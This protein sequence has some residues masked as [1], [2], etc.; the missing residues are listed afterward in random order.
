MKRNSYICILLAGALWGITG[1][2]FR[3]LTA[4]GFDS[5]EAVLMRIGFAAVLLFLF[6]LIRE[7][8]AFRVRL[9]DL[10]CMVGAG[11]ACLMMFICY[12]KA[13]E[14]A[15]LA[16]AVVL[17]YTAPGFVV[18][19][20]A[21]FFKE[22]ITWQ[23][24]LALFALFGGCVCS[25]GLLTGSQTMT[26]QGFLIGVAS[27]FSYSFYSIFC[28]FALD[29]GYS[30]YTTTFYAMFFGTVLAFFAVDFW[31]MIPKIT[32]PVLGYGLGLGFFCCVL[33]YILYNVGMRR[34]ETGEAA[35]LATSEPVV[36]AL[37]GVFLFAEPLTVPVVLGVMLIMMGI[38]IMNH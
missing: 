38:L 26:I 32:V 8:A 33:P 2:F 3:H 23:K 17:L 18:I 10:W 6:L 22:R 19:L 31:G 9:K 7:P 11:T 37:V 28:R 21:F 5:M 24:V 29:R 1:F 35:M 20:S 36:A 14:Y 15:S 16:V 25:S 4:L 30:P 12:F 27:G 34:I 13:M